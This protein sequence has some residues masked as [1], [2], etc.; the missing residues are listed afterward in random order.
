[1][2]QALVLELLLI[3][4]LIVANGFF[5]SAE[6]AIIAAGR[7]PLK[8]LADHGDRKAGVALELLNQPDRFL[9]TVQVGV[10]LVG[11]F[12]AAFSGATLVS[13]LSDRL[14]SLPVVWIRTLSAEI[15]L[16]IVVMALTF[17]SVVLGELVPKRLA[18]LK[19]TE[20]ARLS[21]LPILFLSRIGRPA[22]WC[23]NVATE[24]M[25]FL[26]GLGGAKA[27]TVTVDEIQHLIEQ[28]TAE[29]VLEPVEQKLAVGAL[30]LG[31]R[32]T[33]Q[34]MHPRID[35]DAVDVD[36]P[37]EEL[38]GVV[39]MSGFTRLPVYEGNLDHVI[40]IVHLKDVL[41]QHYL[42]W[43]INLRKLCHKPLFVPETMPLDQLL[44]V[45][46]K[47][48]SQ[49][50][51]VVD[52]FGATKGLVTLD[53]VVTALAGELLAGET[54]PALDRIV[55]RSETSWLVDGT[56]PV[57]ELLAK[58]ELAEFELSLP[59]NVTT[60]AGLVISQLGRLPK[61]GETTTWELLYFEVVD[62]DGQR[63]DKVLVTKKVAGDGRP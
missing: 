37:A 39:A 31:D 52:E 8:R 53:N 35:I 1:M 17:A 51:L 40:G 13:L 48:H 32:S 7:G 62:L 29:G 21:A 2:D 34:I 46:Q 11:T 12:T 43:A 41:R 27:P 9:P 6:I 22:V 3:M 4:V 54:K 19:T 24:A 38:V 28:G 55:Q 23:M 59:R 16:A 49:M 42:G 44:V 57:D 47:Q 25:L 36:T 5:A 61:V 15:A 20:I 18:L 60:L 30:R 14:D 63:V 56:L 10:T 50:A 26:L 45:L 33:R 58:L